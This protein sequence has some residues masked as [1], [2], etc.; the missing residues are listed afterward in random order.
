M[1][2]EKVNRIINCH[3]I[4]VVKEVNDSL[5]YFEVEI[6]QDDILI[7]EIEAMKNNE[8]RTIMDVQQRLNEA[9][10]VDKFRYR[11]Y[12]YLYPNGYGSA[13]VR[14]A[15]YPEFLTFEDYQK[16]LKA[17]EEYLNSDNYLLKYCDEKFELLRLKL[18]S[19]EKYK[20]RVKK[21]VE[22]E[23][24][25]FIDFTR[26]SFQYKR[27][28]YAHRYTE[29]LYEIK[30]DPEVRMW[31]TDQIGWKAFE[32]NVNDDITVYIKSN[33]GY[34]SASY[35]FCNL[36]YKEINI[37]PY[38]SVVKYYYVKMID[39]IRHTRTYAIERNSW[40]QVFDFAIVTANM[41]KHEPERFIKKWI[42]NEVEEMM[43]GIR[44][45]INSPKK[46]LEHFL[47]FDQ[48]IEIG[49]Y[50][51]FRNC[52][53]TDR[54][55]YEVLPGEKVLAFKAEK[56]T[57]C[58]LLL[59]N[60]RSLT[61]IAPIIVPY[62]EEIEQMNRRLLPEIDS[63]IE[64]LERDI[65]RLEDNL[66]AV[67]KEIHAIAPTMKDHNKEIEK[68]RKEMN[69]AKNEASN[70]GGIHTYSIEEAES[71]YIKVHPEYVKQK[72]EYDDLKETKAELEKRI[73]RRNRFL[74]IL[75]KCKNRISKY[76]TAA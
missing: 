60:L 43:V 64:S 15:E 13:Y 56:I 8:N 73:D 69:K 36:K 14:Q 75:V 61:E 23:M 3:F 67:K 57:G 55:D 49:S 72:K 9:F 29:K 74:E 28:L 4:G 18:Q 52:S 24:R 41:A 62:I 22:R 1:E 30:R 25:E 5:K 66:A 20:E 40:A 26:K 53:D 59:D 19:E 44:E 10:P 50:R 47:N 21:I 48:D 27:F 11:S 31:S 45:V 68:L 76:I 16:K 46:K 37:L 7:E 33:F 2:Q 6:P 65:Q 63:H 70:D 38:T 54:K 34:G 58:L 51:L 39:F 32:Y 71:E 35:F 42:V 12:D 17:H